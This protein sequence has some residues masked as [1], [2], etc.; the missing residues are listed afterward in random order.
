LD[1]THDPRNVIGSAG[2][3]AFCFALMRKTSGAGAPRKSVP[4]GKPGAGM[5][6]LGGAP[7][8]AGTYAL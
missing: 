3:D 1:P 4:V 7:S 6:G 5:G 2:L 8:F